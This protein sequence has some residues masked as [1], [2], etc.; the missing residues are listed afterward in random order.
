MSD[1][2]QPN[3]TSTA[4]AWIIAVVAAIALTG[5]GVAMR[6]AGG[7]SGA[8]AGSGAAGS[9][10]RASP[11][12]PRLAPPSTKPAPSSEPPARKYLDV[13]GKT[14]PEQREALMT[15]LERDLDLTEQELAAVRAIVESSDWM[16]QGN[17]KVTTHPMTRAECRKIRSNAGLGDRDHDAEAIC[18]ERNMAPLYDPKAGQK[19]SDAK[20]CIDRFEFPNIPCEYPLVWVRADEADDLCRA[21]GKRICDAGEWEGAC[22]GRLLPPDDDYLWK[23]PRLQAEYYHNQDREIVWSYGREKNHSLCATSSHKSPTCNATTWQQCGS[24]TYPTGAFPRCV[25][26]LGVYDLNGNAA[27]HMNMP[28]KP[29][30][31]ASRGG[32]GET[33]MKGSWFIFSRW[34]AHQDDCRWRAPMW[35]VS[36]LRWKGSHRNYHLGFRC[37]KNRP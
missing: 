14:L 21:E 1:G 22:A 34:E 35:H 6:H 17:P 29:A 32:S 11:R 5:I 15:N 4:R 20:V 27:E 19:A 36:R 9:A 16:G 24:N 28:L 12:E 37:C 10:S 23:E 13:D 7:G 2:P 31:L 33:E 3:A 25:S 26:P 30:E 8:T 18:G